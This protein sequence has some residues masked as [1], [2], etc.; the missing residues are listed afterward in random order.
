MNNIIETLKNHSEDFAPVVPLQKDDK[1]IAIDFTESNKEL[2]DEILSDEDKFVHFMYTK[3]QAEG[4]KYAIGGYDEH[5][6]MYRR[7]SL[8]DGDG[9][10]ARRL[11]LGIDIWGKAH[12]KVMAPLDA[13]VHSLGNNNDFGDYGATIILS[14][15]LDGITFH[16]L[17]GHLS[18][19]SLGDLQ[20]GE[21]LMKGDVF[22]DF[23]MPNENGHW[24]PHLHFQ[25]IVD[26]EGMEGNY[27]G[28][29]KYSE[30]EKYLANCPDA[31][32]IL[33]M[34]EFAE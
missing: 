13:I 32:L 16:T 30:R 25:I 23:G 26:M 7:S 31:D 24:P 20:P 2:T 9:E 10:E 8:F 1:I 17:Y 18:L 5:R 22:A 6:T 19:A 14:H 11:H 3:M 28:V 29:C 34:M 27:P 21:N 15:Q 4:F 12:T 33:R